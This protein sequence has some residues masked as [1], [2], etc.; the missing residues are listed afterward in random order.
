MEPPADRL[1]EPLVGVTALDLAPGFPVNS[2]MI[3][4]TREGNVLI[5]STGGASWSWGTKGLPADATVT[6]LTFGDGEIAAIVDYSAAYRSSDGGESWQPIPGLETEVTQLAYS[7]A[8]RQDGIVFAAGGGAL[9]RSSDRG[10]TWATVLPPNNC[11]INVALSPDLGVDRAPGIA[12][13][14]RC[15]EIVIST[16]GGVSWQLVTR[17]GPE[18]G[19]G[20]LS[21]LKTAPDYLSTGRL[22]AQEDVQGLPLLSRDGGASWQRAFNPGDAP[23]LLGTIAD[24]HFGPGTTLYATGRASLYDSHTSIWL[25]PNEGGT[26]STIGLIPGYD[27]PALALGS[28]GTLW[29]GTGEGIF[30][31][32]GGA[33]RFV[34]PGGSRLQTIELAVEQG[35]AL[36]NRPAGKYTTRVQLYE[37]PANAWQL[38]YEKNADRA[39]RRAFPVPNY[40]AER[41]ILGLAQDYGGQ[42][43][44]MTLRPDAPEPFQ[45]VDAIPTGPGNSLAQYQVTYA[46]DYPASGRIEL[47]HGSSGALYLSTDRGVT[48]SRPDPSE[49]GACE[50]NPVSGFG[51]LWFGNAEV[52]NQLLCPLE[53]EQP[54]TGLAQP[55]EHGEMIRLASLAPP[56]DT[57]V[58]V[59]LPGWE[60]EPSWG[61]MPYYET[62]RPL[63]DPPAGLFS[64]DPLLKTAW[65]EGACC[66]PNAR[67]A[68][69]T[70]GWGTAQA[71]GTTFA[72]QQFE[73]GTMIWR[74]DRD[75]ILVL[76]SETTT[77]RFQAYGD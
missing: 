57:T 67:P 73:G 68:Q 75:E 41:L 54:Y 21:N 28:D 55:F 27:R 22:L 53:E 4:G 12:L 44:V 2:A 32:A 38:A 1:D 58:Y 34:H 36:V 40:P 45:V 20:N 46:G 74:Q 72:R 56:L 5:S 60:G 14:P 7:P 11:P 43:W 66:R 71:A 77:D 6:D 33:W 69:E 70:L 61:T 65:L 30:S 51:T 50:R 13:A 23:F 10:A 17:Q 59:L 3:A 19:V 15:N 31:Y 25:S 39:P 29:A 62:D 9:L 63:P 76:I 49:P 64:P 24:V 52:R 35:V 37:K 47:R 16:D 26:W 18:P 8:Y 48:W 42:I